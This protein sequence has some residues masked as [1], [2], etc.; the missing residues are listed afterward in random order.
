MWS[1]SGDVQVRA[2]VEADLA[3]LTELSDAA[4]GFEDS[5]GAFPAALRSGEL[6]EEEWLPAIRPAVLVGEAHR[7]PPVG[8]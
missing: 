1:G 7:Q 5:L 3:A 4:N 8:Q 6:S 2:G